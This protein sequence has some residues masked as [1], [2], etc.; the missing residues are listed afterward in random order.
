MSGNDIS[1]IGLPMRSFMA[2]SCI[3]PEVQYVM[4]RLCKLFLSHALLDW[5]LRYSYAC[6]SAADE[7]DVC[8]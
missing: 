7:L 5:H 1:K 8:L 4:T 3:C 2:L 6:C